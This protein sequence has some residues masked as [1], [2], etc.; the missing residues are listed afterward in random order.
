VCARKLK[1]EQASTNSVS[2]TLVPANISQ[3]CSH[4]MI[5]LA[6]KEGCEEIGFC[7]VGH[8][9]DEQGVRSHPARA[10]EC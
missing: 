2:L 4:N 6:R 7:F 3:L 1:A 8:Y 9:P 5:K 10:A